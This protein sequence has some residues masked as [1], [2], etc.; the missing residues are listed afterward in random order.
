MP[1]IDRA[2]VVSRAKA[3]PRSSDTYRS[4]RRHMARAMYKNMK[5]LRLSLTFNEFWLNYPDRIELPLARGTALR[6]CVR[7]AKTYSYSGKR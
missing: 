5:Q 3:M 1:R 4:V 7:N 2:S 6:R